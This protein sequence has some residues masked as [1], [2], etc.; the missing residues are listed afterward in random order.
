MNIAFEQLLSFAYQSAMGLLEWSWQAVILLVCVWFLLQVRRTSAPALRHQI[1]LCGLIV[2][3]A[4]PLWSPLLRQMP[5]LPLTRPASNILNP[6]A[7][8]KVETLPALSTEIVANAAPVKNC[9]L[10]R[11]QTI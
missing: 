9:D 5:Q 7:A 1:W 8:L 6:L 4:M 10:G 3:A 11:F 2:V